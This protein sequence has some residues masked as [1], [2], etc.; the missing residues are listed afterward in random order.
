METIIV[1]LNISI[2]ALYTI[3]AL[4]AVI[5]PLPILCIPRFQRRNNMFTLN[6]CLATAIHCMAWLPTSIL[7]LFGHSRVLVSFHRPVDRRHMPDD[8][9]LRPS[10][11]DR[12]CSQCSRRFD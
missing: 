5:Y 9:R 6:V 1:T 3:T 4:L 7:S 12:V 2:V 10:K 8:S 11:M